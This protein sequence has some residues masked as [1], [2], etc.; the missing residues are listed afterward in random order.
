MAIKRHSDEVNAENRRI[1]QWSWLCQG[2]TATWARKSRK[3]L[4]RQREN[5]ELTPRTT[6]SVAPRQVEGTDQKSGQSLPYP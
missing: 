6:T 5:H 1:F 2:V 4:S 3:Q